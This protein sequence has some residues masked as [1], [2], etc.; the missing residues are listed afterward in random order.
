MMRSAAEY[1]SGRSKTPYT[2]LKI[3]VVAPIAS[4]S[5]NTMM[6]VTP[7]FL[8]SPRAAHRKSRQNPLML[9]SPSKSFPLTTA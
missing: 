2:T 9:P 6:A 4:A 8:P 5:V 1:G 7:G 3:A